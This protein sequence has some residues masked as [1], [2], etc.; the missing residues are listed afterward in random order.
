M[1]FIC[2]LFNSL[3]A[4]TQA[5]SARPE[6]QASGGGGT[7]SDASGTH[8]AGRHLCM[9][10]VRAERPTPSREPPQRTTR[11]P[12]VLPHNTPSSTL[13]RMRG[14]GLTNVGASEYL[15]V[16]EWTHI[17]NPCNCNPFNLNC[18]VDFPSQELIGRFPQGLPKLDPVEDM[19]IV[20]DAFGKRLGELR[21]LE[22]ELTR[23]PH[24]K[25]VRDACAVDLLPILAT[26]GDSNDKGIPR[27]SVSHRSPGS[28]ACCT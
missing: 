23:N 6:R 1:R 20:D 24:H 5:G 25:E 8:F 11:H 15:L 22:L 12:G 27:A 13:F 21:Q 4:F 26:G 17:A 3:L 2:V 16:Q 18:L 14:G 7:C 28:L 19:G 9:S 10:G